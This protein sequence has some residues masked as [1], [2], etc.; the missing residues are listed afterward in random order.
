MY[1]I[2]TAPYDIDIPVNTQQGMT[3]K[4]VS[5]NVRDSITEALFSKHL[6]LAPTD[7]L[8]REPIS[9]KINNIATDTAVLTDEEYKVLLSS[10]EALRG[11][12]QYDME[13][14]KRIFNASKQDE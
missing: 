7:I 12:T 5:Y 10:V 11:L 13:F 4:K 2:N 3:K 8:A 14:V 9:E 6:G 1:T